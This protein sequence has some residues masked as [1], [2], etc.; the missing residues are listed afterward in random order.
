MRLFNTYTLLILRTS[1]AGYRTDRVETEVPVLLAPRARRHDVREVGP[2]AGAGLAAALRAEHLGEAKHCPN[3]IFRA[4]P[5]WLGC[6]QG[7]AEV[8]RVLRMF[9]GRFG[10]VQGIFRASN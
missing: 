4:F 5:K 2:H 7:V 9:L 3:T 1:P 8:S 10:S 6:F